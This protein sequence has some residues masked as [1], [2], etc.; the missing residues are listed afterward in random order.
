M[1]E[2]RSTG[3]SQGVCG[4]RCCTSTDLVPSIY[5]LVPQNNWCQK[6]KV[7][8]NKS[9]NRAELSRNLPVKW[10]RKKSVSLGH[11]IVILNKYFGN[12]SDKNAKILCVRGFILCLSPFLKH[13]LFLFLFPTKHLW[14]YTTVFFLLFINICMFSCYFSVRYYQHSFCLLVGNW[15]S[16]TVP[17]PW[18][19]SNYRQKEALW[20]VRPCQFEIRSYDQRIHCVSITDFALHWEVIILC[21]TK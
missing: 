13:Q 4:P 19:G 16:F 20:L 12:A 7:N 18:M 2:P 6:K 10:R 1:V 14:N 3:H 11:E 15:R 21:F 8:T 9:K 5:S 17:G